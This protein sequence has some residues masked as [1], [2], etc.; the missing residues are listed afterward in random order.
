MIQRMGGAA[1]CYMHLQEQAV[2]GGESRGGSAS[3]ASAASGGW[4]HRKTPSRQVGRTAREE[5]GHANHA[6]Q[7]GPV[8]QL[9][10]GGLSFTVARDGHALRCCVLYAGMHARCA[11]EVCHSEHG[12]EG[13]NVSR[14]GMAGLLLLLHHRCVQNQQSTRWSRS[15]RLRG[16]QPPGRR[17]VSSGSSRALAR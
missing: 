10:K 13:L 5:H 6:R 2:E 7:A 9:A 12:D 3:I 1:A 14:R 16:R 8:S 4:H 15:R 17:A 11:R